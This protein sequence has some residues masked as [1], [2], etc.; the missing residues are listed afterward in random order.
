ME[1]NKKEKNN[2]LLGFILTLF[3]SSGLVAIIL[4]IQAIFSGDGLLKV[5]ENYF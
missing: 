4:I 3:V 5:L 2:I 1:N